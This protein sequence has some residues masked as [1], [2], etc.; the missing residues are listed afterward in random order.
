M[1]AETPLEESA[2]AFPSAQEPA[3]GDTALDRIE[4]TGN[5]VRAGAAL[6]AQGFPAVTQD[7][8]LKPEDWLLRVRARRDAGQAEQARKSLQEF[9][10][11]YPYLVVPEGLRALLNERP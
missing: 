7:A 5:R 4:V 11:S 1:Q 3:R 6:D 10:R 2:G 9:V 8:R